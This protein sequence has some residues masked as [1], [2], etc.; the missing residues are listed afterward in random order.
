M[1]TSSLAL[2]QHTT[3]LTIVSSKLFSPPSSS[4]LVSVLPPSTSTSPSSSSSSSASLLAP[5]L[6]R[7]KSTNNSPRSAGKAVAAALL[8]AGVFLKEARE[9]GGLLPSTLRDTC[10]ALLEDT[11]RLLAAERVSLGLRGDGLAGVAC[12]GLSFFM[13]GGVL[14]ADTFIIFTTMDGVFVRSLLTFWLVFWLAGECEED[15]RPVLGVF[16]PLETGEA[17]VFRDAVDLFLGMVSDAGGDFKEDDE[18]FFLEGVTAFFAAGD[19]V[20]FLVLFDGGGDFKD[21]DEVFF[22]D[23]VTVF[24]AGDVAFKLTD[25]FF[26]EGITGFSDSLRERE[27]ALRFGGEDSKCVG[28]KARFFAGDFFAWTGASVL[29]GLRELRDT[30]RA[31]V[32]LCFLEVAGDGAILYCEADLEVGIRRVFLFVGGSWSKS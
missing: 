10:L 19:A 28:D 23:G 1:V 5:S 4:T 22:L 30:G 15:G 24:L 18:D 31:L 17:A 7:T 20:D 26:G 11:M 25:V 2:L 21:D 6:N 3:H 9:E 14:M 32:D 12:L 8:D 27:A 29:G 13:D 16:C